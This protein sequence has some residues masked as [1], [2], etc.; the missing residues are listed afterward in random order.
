MWGRLT[1]YT[2]RNGAFEPNPQILIRRGGSNPQRAR[3][4]SFGQMVLVL[5]PKQKDKK[6]NHDF[7]GLE[8]N[9]MWGHFAKYTEHGNANK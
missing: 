3:E 4:P 7:N 8:T 1:N 6:A 5:L 9:R 2:E